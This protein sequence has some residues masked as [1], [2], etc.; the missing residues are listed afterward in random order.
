MGGLSMSDVTHTRAVQSLD[1]VWDFVHASDGIVRKVHVPN[2]W[3]AEFPDLRQHS[4]AAT[5]TRRFAHPASGAGRE[6]VLRFGAAS[7]FATVRVNGTEVGRHEG[8]YLPFNCVIPPGLLR[9]DNDLS[10]D[11]VLPDGDPSTAGSISFAEV[12]HGKQSWYGPLGGLWQSVML[13]VRDPV[14]LDHVAISADPVT[15]VV[16]AKLT[17]AGSATA[18]LTVIAPDGTTVAESRDTTLIVPNP[19]AWSPDTPHLYTLRIDLT[20]DGLCDR[21][22][23]CFGFRSITTRNGQVLLNGKPFYMRGALDQD[24]YPEGICTPPST[25][26]LEDQLRKAKALGL[27]TLRCH[28]KIPDPRY[29]E[30]ADRLGMLIWTEIPNVAFFT[31]DS[32]RRMRET[33]DGILRR[34]GN[35]PS[36]AI[37]TLINED[38]GTRLC[39]DAEHRAW[40]KETFDWLK[41]RDPT[42]LVVDNSPCHGN[43]HVKTDL[44]D[45]H[46][47]RSVPERRL[48]WDTLTAEFAAGADWTWTPFGDGDRKG[49]EPLIVSEFGVWG[50]PDPAQVTI[51]NAEPWWMETGQTWGDGAAYPHGVQSR[52]DTLNMASVFG[53]FENFIEQVQWYQFMNLKY[54]IEVMRRHPS[55]MG[56]VITEFTDVHWESNGLLDMN[57]NPR[58]FHDRFHKINAD[59]VIVPSLDRYAGTA[60]GAFYF[61]LGVGT[62][63]KSHG[64][65]VLHW[66]DETG[67]G[68]QIPLPALAPLSFGSAGQV[69][70]TLPEGPSRILRIDLWLTEGGTEVARNQVD[71]AVHAKRST[72]VLPTVGSPNDRLADWARTLGYTVVPLDQAQVVLV[73]AL[74]GTEIAHLQSGARYVV[75]A[76]GTKET[77]RNLRLDEGRREQPFIPI[78]DETPGLPANPEGQSPNINLIPRQGTMW[79]GDW[80]AGFSWIRRKGVFADLPGGPLVDLSFDRVVPHHVMTGFRAWEMAGPIHAGLVVGWVHKPAALIVERRV[81]RGGMVASTFRLF[82]ERP[83]ADPLADTLFDRLVKLAATMAVDGP[84]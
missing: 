62:G 53:S 79:R 47:Y 40:L 66:Q 20:T 10:V 44:N 8:G 9:E 7:Y 67:Q 63:T 61:D 12:P 77:L 3:Q 72:T 33:M 59:T 17:I 11:C 4:G 1:G 57:R 14:H 41:E 15:G 49:D 46:W 42:R 75:F 69:T 84:A 43:F 32:A 52:F 78:V 28:I 83:G 18:T 73:H 60:G 24:Y 55:I 65:T 23:H 36:I 27:N 39:E 21:T 13:E 31:A 30:V 29:Y 26:F 45:F 71:F 80:I 76:D 64:A 37:W 34:D 50:L 56:Y 68:G 74:D 58:V 35:H 54:E 5:Y 16:A 25:A 82:T 51:N 6:T 48:E 19:L 81:G 22:E 2:P 70:L 38:W